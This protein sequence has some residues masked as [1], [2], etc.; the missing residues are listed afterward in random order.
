MGNVWP[1]HTL[2]LS[3]RKPQFVCREVSDICRPLQVHYHVYQIV[4]PVGNEDGQV[5][6]HT[7]VPE[8]EAPTPWMQV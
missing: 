2:Q 3:L 4:Q 6:A 8:G 5:N 1:S 7:H